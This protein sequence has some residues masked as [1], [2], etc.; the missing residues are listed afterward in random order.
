LTGFIGE[1][2]C[3]LDAKGRLLI[4]SEM[5]KQ[6]SPED[7]GQFI[8]SRGVD[9]C[10]SLYTSTEWVQVMNKLR[11][12]NRFKPKDRKF[13][14]MFQKGATK[15]MVD[16]SGRILIPKG[17]S[18]W[19]SLHKEVVLVANVDLWELWDKER[20]EELMREDWDG[21]DQLAQDVMGDSTDGE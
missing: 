21:F 10:L 7:H 8:V 20:Y 9:D 14:R 16:G 17:L 4:P 1:Y 13:A 3:K 11:K 6:L 18:S 12:L 2:H 19:A 15:V 5:R